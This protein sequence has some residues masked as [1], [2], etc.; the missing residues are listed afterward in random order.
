VTNPVTKVYLELARVQ[1][2]PNIIDVAERAAARIRR[3]RQVESEK[4]GCRQALFDLLSL[5]S[6]TFVY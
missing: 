2:D 1:G 3:G 5:A 4:I 6:P